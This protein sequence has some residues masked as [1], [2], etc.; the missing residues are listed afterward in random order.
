MSDDFHKYPSQ[1]ADRFQVRMPEGMRDQLRRAAEIS[2]RS[3]NAEI[4]HRLQ[5]SMH[6]MSAEEVQATVFDRRGGPGSTE[7]VPAPADL[8]VH[9]VTKA[10]EAAVQQ[11][12]AELSHQGLTAM[13]FDAKARHN[14][15]LFYKPPAGSSDDPVPGQIDES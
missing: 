6:F 7:N 12:I 10:V 15:G 4:V 9:E 5:Q 14:P 1:M 11:K 13:Y 3:M 8:L 2:G